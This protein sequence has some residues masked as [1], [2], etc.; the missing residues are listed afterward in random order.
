MAGPAEVGWLPLGGRGGVLAHHGGRAVP[1]NPGLGLALDLALGLGTGAGVGGVAAG[2][3][4]PPGRGPVRWDPG[5][6]CGPA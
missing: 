2:P 3:F 1:G 6:G 5:S 4:P